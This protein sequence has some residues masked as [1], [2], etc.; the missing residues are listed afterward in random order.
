MS[1]PLGESLNRRLLGFEQTVPPRDAMAQAVRA[2]S[3]LKHRRA[4]VAQ[5]ASQLLGRD[6]PVG[7]IVDGLFQKS[8]LAV[9]PDRRIGQRAGLAGPRMVLNEGC[10][11]R[12]IGRQAELHKQ[13]GHGV[14]RTLH[15]VFLSPKSHLSALA[16][17]ALYLLGV[18]RVRNF[19]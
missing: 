5:E 4:A 3:A 1:G 6:G 10:Y 16:R 14:D 18:G 8:P 11:R 9:G 15:L 17:M 7:V 2:P 19:V 13:I 12:G